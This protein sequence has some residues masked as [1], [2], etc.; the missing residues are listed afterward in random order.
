[1]YLDWEK[2]T[3]GELERKEA[4]VPSL[5][6]LNLMPN[7]SPNSYLF[8]IQRKMPKEMRAEINQHMQPLLSRDI[9]RNMEGAD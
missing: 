3:A 7:P 4:I 2:E 9:H 6:S 1:M 5:T 8:W